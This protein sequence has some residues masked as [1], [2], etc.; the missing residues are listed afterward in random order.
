MAGNEE[1][2][3]LKPCSTKSTAAA[4][5]VSGDECPLK[6]GSTKRKV[7]AEEHDEEDIVLAESTIDE[8][9]GQATKAAVADSDD[10]SGDDDEPVSDAEYKALLDELDEK[11]RKFWHE[12]FL[13]LNPLLK[14]Y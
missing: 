2:S 9:K 8:T 5:A 14:D 11:H 1:S 13:P 6:I 7:P 3:S 4:Q 10:G 12:E